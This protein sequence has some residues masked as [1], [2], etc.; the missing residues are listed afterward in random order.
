MGYGSPTQL[1]R[2]QNTLGAKSIWGF[3]KDIRLSR[4]NDQLLKAFLPV[5]PC[6]GCQEVREQGYVR[7][8]ERHSLSCKLDYQ[9]PRE[10]LR[11]PFPLRNKNPWMGVLECGKEE[12]VESISAIRRRH[13]NVPTNLLILLTTKIWFGKSSAKNRRIGGWCQASQDSSACPR[14]CQN[15]FK[16]PDTNFTCNA[17]KKQESAGQ[18]VS[19]EALRS[20]RTS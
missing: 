5:K 8:D 19:L 15:L 14:S 10:T 6:K 18:T 17:T 2:T 11:I 20:A 13:L 16:M 1:L 3:G 9:E 12:K 4:T 7:G